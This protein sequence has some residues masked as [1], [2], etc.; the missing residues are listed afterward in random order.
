ML[1]TTKTLVHIGT[2]RDFWVFKAGKEKR[3]INK[4]RLR[5]KM[6]NTPVAANGVLYVATQ[7]Y[8]YAVGA[9]AGG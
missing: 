2:E 8:L 7:R 1:C 6:Y 9:A 5:H 3:L 4:V